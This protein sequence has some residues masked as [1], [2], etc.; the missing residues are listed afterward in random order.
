[1]SWLADP[2]AQVHQATGMVQV[3]LRSTTDVALMRLR[4]HAFT[5]NVP[6]TDVARQVV[7]RSLRF[8]DTEDGQ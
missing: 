2:Y 5:H 6:L 4:G 1:M 8:T 3:Q 7:E